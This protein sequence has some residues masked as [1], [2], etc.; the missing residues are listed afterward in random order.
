[1]NPDDL[2]GSMLLFG[3]IAGALAV[4]AGYF[5]NGLLYRWLDRREA[6]RDRA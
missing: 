3:I 6:A 2:V 4:H 5:L 1:V